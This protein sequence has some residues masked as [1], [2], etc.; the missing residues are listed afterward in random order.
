[1][2]LFKRDRDLG[3]FHAINKE[4]VN[5]IIDTRVAIFKINLL[6]TDVNIYGE[7]IN[8]VY[9]PGIHVHALVDHINPEFET[10][11]FGPDYAQTLQIRF[12]RNTLRSAGVYPE[13]G[14]V[15]EWNNNYYELATAVEDQI[16]GGQQ[17]AQHN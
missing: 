12:H 8:K 9:Y 1:M 11:D 3:L 4:I 14:D 2:P 7:G 6:D 16:V 10:D 13:V 17:D 15:V 5:S